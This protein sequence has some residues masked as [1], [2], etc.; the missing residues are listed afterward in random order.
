MRAA[1]EEETREGNSPVVGFLSILL[2]T[3]ELCPLPYQIDI[4]MA[5]IDRIF[6]ISER[7]TS[8]E[9]GAEMLV[10]S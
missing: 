9:N 5:Q 8:K 3:A 7:Q 10:L 2:P 4:I 1:T 6:L